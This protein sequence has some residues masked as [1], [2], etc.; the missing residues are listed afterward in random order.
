MMEIKNERKSERK[1]EIVTENSGVDETKRKKENESAREK[2]A[3]GKGNVNERE[4]VIG[5]AEN[6][7]SR[8]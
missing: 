8:G 2:N 4:N 3:S 5:S 1:N 6:G 7:S